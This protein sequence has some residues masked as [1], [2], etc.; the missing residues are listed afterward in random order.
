VRS[1]LPGT[2][3]PEPP[4]R[5][6]VGKATYP[7]VSNRDEPGIVGYFGDLE[8][9]ALVVTPGMSF[10]I[11]AIHAASEAHAAVNHPQKVLSGQK[12]VGFMLAP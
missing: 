5:R 9:A 8:A 1:R 2:L 10:S 3:L 4:L 6:G 11:P 7:C 12:L